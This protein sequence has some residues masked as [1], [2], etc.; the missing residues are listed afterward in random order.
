MAKLMAID[1]VTPEKKVFEGNIREMIAPGLEGE[2]G[3]LPEHAP[4]ATILQPGVVTIFKEDG[5]QDLIAVSGGYIEVT[6]EKVVLLVE[7]AEFPEELD[8]AAVK[9]RKE[10]KERL[11]KS[12]RKG[13]QDYDAIQASLMSEISRLRAMELLQRKKQ[14]R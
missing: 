11:L 4:F 10:E 13:D 8:L 6:R 9:R 7:T 3:V 2:F 1:I 12:K 14:K 5:S